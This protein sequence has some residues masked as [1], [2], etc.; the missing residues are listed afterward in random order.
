M[1]FLSNNFR[2]KYVLSKLHSAYKI[3]RAL[4]RLVWKKPELTL[5]YLTGLVTACQVPISPKMWHDRTRSGRL[6]FLGG[7]GGRTRNG[8]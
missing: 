2:A 3:I 1:L 7:G 4:L 8:R 5:S 6:F